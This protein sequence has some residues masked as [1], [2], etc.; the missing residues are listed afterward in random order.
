M[1]CLLGA[2]LLPEALLA[3]LLEQQGVSDL[4]NYLLFVATAAVKAR[5][6]MKLEF[7]GHRVAYG[8]TMA[9]HCDHQVQCER[10][11]NEPSGMELKSSI[12]SMSVTP[13]SPSRKPA[14]SA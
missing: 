7:G 13:A 1:P 4:D 14:S 12:L 9:E 11:G 6:V 8:P 5:A 3:A 2:L 10:N